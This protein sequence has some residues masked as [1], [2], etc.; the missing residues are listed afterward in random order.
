MG[1]QQSK[2]ANSSPSSPR[3]PS[4]SNGSRSTHVNRDWH[5]GRHSSVQPANVDPARSRSIDPSP[6]HAFSP[7]SSPPFHRPAAQ[8]RPRRA[9]E[10]T[11]PPGVR[12]GNSQSHEAETERQ[13]AGRRRDRHHH[14]HQQHHATLQAPPPPAPQQHQQQQQSHPV[15]VPEG[16]S[17]RGRA[18]TGIESSSPP[19]ASGPGDYAPLSSNLN[20]PPR[21][22]LP[23]QE[24]D[25]TPGSPIITAVD[26]LSPHGRGARTGVGTGGA[27]GGIETGASEL[28]VLDDDGGEGTLPHQSSLLSNNTT[29]DGE[30]E[31]RETDADADAAEESKG[32]TV[33]TVIK[34]RQPGSR[35]YITGTFAAWSKKYRMHRE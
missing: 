35:V 33:P 34:W 19:S 7:P 21:L 27:D 32:R 9:T 3:P 15:Q 10:A 23:I 28:T 20:F 11:A 6:T 12:M 5:H 8:Q 4:H 31:E 13:D 18:P 29:V 26:V 16:R 25:Y 14:H 1:N 30:E 22:P 17:T 2:H 24:E